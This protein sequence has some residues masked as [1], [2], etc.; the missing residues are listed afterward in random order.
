M[1]VNRKGQKLFRSA[2]HD[3]LALDVDGFTFISLC[4]PSIIFLLVLALLLLNVLTVV[5]HQRDLRLSIDSVNAWNMLLVPV[6]FAD[7]TRLS[8]CPAEHGDHS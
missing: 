7:P 1:L 8:I 4:L 6:P 3:L 5:A 2:V